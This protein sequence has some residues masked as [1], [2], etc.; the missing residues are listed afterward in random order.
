MDLII[1][2]N[3]DEWLPKPGWRFS[4]DSVEFSRGKLVSLAEAL[5]SAKFTSQLPTKDRVHA[6]RESRP[7]CWSRFGTS[8]HGATNGSPGRPPAHGAAPP[9]GPEAARWPRCLTSVWRRAA[10]AL[11][12][13]PGDVGAAIWEREHERASI[14]VGR[15]S[16]PTGSFARV[17]VA[18][19]PERKGS[20]WTPVPRS[21]APRAQARRRR[22]RRR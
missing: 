16:D 21:V 6:G 14:S 4:R 13:A 1:L 22:R 20:P 12:H 5:S 10:H 9:G 11:S 19:V 15:A 7:A 18:A 2:L 17:R 3:S 8:V